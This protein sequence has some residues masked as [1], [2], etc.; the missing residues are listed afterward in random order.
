MFNKSKKSIGIEVN[1][2]SIRVVE[3][4]KQEKKIAVS[5]KSEL[6]L[7]KGIIERGVIKNSN[8]LV[9]SIN[10]A[11]AQAEP[12]SI[13]GTR[14]HFSIPDERVYTH[15]FELDSG[16]GGLKNRA[17]KEYRDNI[18][19]SEE[20]GIFV[21]KAIEKDSKNS[22]NSFNVVVVATRKKTILNWQNIFEQINKEI[23]LFDTEGL[24][25]YRT[26]HSEYQ[27][28]NIL[29]VDFS[30]EII[31]ISFF[32]KNSIR[33]NYSIMSGF[34]KLL[35][36]VMKMKNIGE[37]E[38]MTYIFH[39]DQS[40]DEKGGNLIN[41]Y[42][43]EVGLE[44][45]EH[46][47]YY[48][49]RIVNNS[50]D[51]FTDESLLVLYGEYFQEKIINILKSSL[52]NSNVVSF[53]SSED[54]NDLEQKYYRCVGLAMRE[55][56]HKWDKTDPMFISG[57]V[58]NEYL[59]IKEV[60]SRF[61]DYKNLFKV[62][63]LASFILT[64]SL[65]VWFKTSLIRNSQVSESEIEN[66]VEEINVVEEAPPIYTDKM[67]IV[68]DE[69][70][71]KLNVRASNSTSSEIIGQI[72]PGSEYELLEEKDLWFKILLNEEF[73]GWVSANYATKT[74]KNILLND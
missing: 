70:G 2:H 12:Q 36:E 56:Y 41:N 1:D 34:N 8:L 26:L 39:D 27:G 18:P 22:S 5:A 47:E 74:T 58:G 62:V 20:D 44:I 65:V 23:E 9:K 64:A 37:T 29:L 7:E 17:L 66:A 45:K 3:L 46:I 69:I 53:K 24:S 35:D 49:S 38:A 43:E 14:L 52:R 72:E 31:Q 51:Q 50:K 4:E 25:L 15:I 57:V 6:V 54:F 71:M 19:I 16:L 60:S 28:K 42:F 59:K 48:N 40:N 21:Y 55:F 13:K 63:L 10:K 61:F 32:T 67:F 30:R 73:E 11:F 68:V 33:Y